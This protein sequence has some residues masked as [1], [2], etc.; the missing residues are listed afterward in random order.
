MEKGRQL[1]LSQAYGDAL[2]KKKK[3]PIDQVL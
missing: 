2:K 3:K 1:N